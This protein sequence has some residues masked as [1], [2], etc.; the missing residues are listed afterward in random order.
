MRVN[1]G[2]WDQLTRLVL[3]LLFLAGLLAL[4]FWYLPNIQT[5]ERY[6]RAS[7]ILDTK[8]AEQERIARQLKSQT[9]AV[10]NDPRTLER[11]A[12]EK[13]G[14]AKSNETVIVFEPPR[15]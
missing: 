2:I 7:L 6:R 9:D 4:F 1:L 15:P 14:W 11:L 12:R 10:L 13:L 3:F 8:I 5:N